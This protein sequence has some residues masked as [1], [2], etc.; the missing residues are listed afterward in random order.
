[1]SWYKSAKDNVESIEKSNPK[2]TPTIS[3]GLNP[4]EEKP[5]Q[6]TLERQLSNLEKPFVPPP[7]QFLNSTPDTMMAGGQGALYNAKVHDDANMPPG[8]DNYINTTRWN[9]N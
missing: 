5:E 4:Q 1:M 3:P 6:E 2:I 9:E 7:N 8:G